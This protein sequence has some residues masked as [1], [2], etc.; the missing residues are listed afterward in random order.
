MN[1]FIVA[2]SCL[3]AARITSMPSLRTPS[4]IVDARDV[5]D[6]CDITSSSLS[7]SIAVENSG[8][9]KSLWFI[10]VASPSVLF[11]SPSPVEGSS[12]EACSWGIV[13]GIDSLRFSPRSKKVPNC[14]A[15]PP[16]H[17]DLATLERM[18]REHFVSK[19]PVIRHLSVDDKINIIII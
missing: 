18:E 13:D 1:F 10:V 9:P 6:V 3:W 14:R 12:L 4:K 17:P 11:S 7:W 2:D 5:A 19:F 8:V 15:L 16:G